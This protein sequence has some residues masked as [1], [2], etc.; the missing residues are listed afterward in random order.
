MMTKN[1]FLLLLVYGFLSHTFQFVFL[2]VSSLILSRH[3]ERNNCRDLW[4][5]HSE[6]KSRPSWQLSVSFLISDSGWLWDKFSLPFSI[7]QTI[8]H[9][10]N[11]GKHNSTGDGV[12]LDCNGCTFICETAFQSSLLADVKE[13]K[14]V[15]RCFVQSW[16]MVDDWK[17]VFWLIKFN[18]K[19][20]DRILFRVIDS[21]NPLLYIFFPIFIKKNI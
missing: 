1:T 20:S 16:Q 17:K 12:N 6:M 21:F 8:I 3:W 14:Y 7:P 2:E 13:K 10:S 15:M 19:A 18:A 4:L 5:F 9:C 11:C